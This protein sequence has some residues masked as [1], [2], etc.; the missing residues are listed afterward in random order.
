MQARYCRALALVVVA[1][2]VA[3]GVVADVVPPLEAPPPHNEPK[4]RYISFVPNNP[5]MVT[6]YRV[7]LSASDTFPNSVGV[8]GW[9]DT[10]FDPGCANEGDPPEECAGEYIARLVCMPVFREWD[11]EYVHVGDPGIAPATVYGIRAS[12]E[13]GSL[14]AVFA[15]PTPPQPLPRYWGDVVG[16]K[17]GDP[18]EWSGPNGHVNVN[19]ILAWVQFMV[20]PLDSAPLTWIDLHGLGEGN[21]PNYIINVSDLHQIKLG[22]WGLE[23][24]FLDPALYVQPG[25]AG[26]EDCNTNGVCDVCEL[27]SGSA[28]DC[29]V[30]GAPDDCDISSGFSDDCLPDGVPDECEP[31]CNENEVADACDIAGGFSTDCNGNTIPDDCESDCNGNAIPDDCDIVNDPQQHADTD[32]DR[33][34]DECE[35]NTG[36]LVATWDA[37]SDP[38]D[39]DSDGD[40]INDGD[41]VVGTLGGLDLP[42][43]GANPNR[44]TLLVEVDWIDDDLGSPHSHRPSDAAV[45]MLID[46]FAAAP[47]ANPDPTFPAG[48]ELVVDYGQDAGEPAGVFTGGNLIPDGASTVGWPDLFDHYKATHFAAERLGYFRYGI[49]AHRYSCSGCEFFSSGVAEQ[50]GDDFMVTLQDYVDDSNVSKT[51][52][53]ELGHNLGLAH[54]GFEARQY[55]PNYNSVM[56]RRYQFSGVDTDCDAYGDGVLDYSHGVLPDLDEGSL[57]ELLGICGAFC[58][59]GCPVDWNADQVISRVIAYN[60]NCFEGLTAPCGFRPDSACDTTCDLHQDHDDWANLQYSISQANRA[61]SET[62]KCQSVSLPTRR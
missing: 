62:V 11:E 21:P 49:H 51:T 55:K 36:V 2:G 42:A 58:D 35:T 19:D 14:S 4:N 12:D 6:A 34:L 32:G 61:A 37:G 43:L 20:D 10:P 57:D 13:A 45:Q 33:L 60:I 52:M 3:D 24:P 38:Y 56:N 53:H 23:Y 15:V 27:A 39:P 47:V 28:E 31:D 22:F 44:K 30:N 48:I 46:A 8:V 59:P 7:E 29:N 9:V 26:C 50:P 40:G 54:G 17:D 25:P 18:P 1:L 16:D 5:G 41:E